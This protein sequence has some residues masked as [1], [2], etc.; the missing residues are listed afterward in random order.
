MTYDQMRDRTERRRREYAQGFIV[1]TSDFYEEERP[2][3]IPQRRER[4]ERSS[5]HH[6]EDNADETFHEDENLLDFDQQFMEIDF[7]A[8]EQQMWWQ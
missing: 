7:G 4:P 3:R 8:N 6:E 2:I 1:E 5:G